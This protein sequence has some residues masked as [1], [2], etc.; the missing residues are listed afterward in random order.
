MT[1]IIKSAEVGGRYIEIAQDKFSTGYA[2]RAFDEF[3]RTLT[4]TYYNDIKKA[5]RR[6]R[7]LER[8]FSKDT[9]RNEINEMVRH[10]NNQIGV[11]VV[12]VRAGLYDDEV[13]GDEIWGYTIECGNGAETLRT[14]DGMLK[15]LLLAEDY[16][17][18]E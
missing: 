2:V 9:M 15:G 6:F 5:E 3:G 16:R 18:D 11:D 17:C 10:L 13:E 14:L 4:E 1:V 8:G 7:D 12:R